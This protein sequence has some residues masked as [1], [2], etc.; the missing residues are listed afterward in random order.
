ME[1]LI[2][3][4]TLLIDRK[5]CLNNISKISIKA[6]KNNLIFR[7]HFKTHQSKII[8]QW[9]RDAGVDKITVSSF[10]MAD[11]FASAGWEDITIAFPVNLRELDQINHLSSKIKLNILV[12]DIN[13]ISRL[14]KGLRSNTG[15]Y[16][17]IDT[18]YNR[19]GLGVKDYQQID[20]ALKQ[21]LSSRQLKFK[22]FL[23]H[24]GDTY[25]AKSKVEV[26][27]IHDNNINSLNDLKR[28]FV[29]IAPE[30]K[31]SIGDTP[32]CS[33][34]D[35]FNGIDEIRPGNFVFYDLMQENIGSCTLNEISLI[36]L[37]PVVS[38]NSIREEIVIYGGAIHMS[39]EFIID[40]SGNKLFGKVV[41]PGENLHWG[42]VL[43]NTFLAGIS[44]EHGIIKT[45]AEGLKRI[46]IGDLVG[47]LPVHSCL[48]AN[49]MS[50]YIDQDKNRLDHMNSQY[51]KD[52][53]LR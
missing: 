45:D 26:I 31:I 20:I 7:P 41:L 53:Y 52:P 27:S 12:S 2:R 10:M 15:V 32:S 29:S 6:R 33:I 36:V 21:L 44:Q 28:N 38:V 40:K 8:S 3:K 43:K 17:E 47:I 30:L 13:S 4:P 24:A 49:L 16:I 35:N 51:N 11:Y 34:A 9:F 39:K 42:D 22:G 37:C 48:T 50:D 46:K 1:Y 23:C 25:N 14:E 5:K 18:G 19:S